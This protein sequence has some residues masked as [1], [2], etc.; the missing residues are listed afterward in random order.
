MGG[1]KSADNVRGRG[2]KKGEV[3]NKL[4]GSRKQRVRKGAREAAAEHEQLVSPKEVGHQLLVTI[5]GGQEIARLAEE[6][7]GNTYKHAFAK[8]WT[9]AIETGDWKGVQWFVEY[10][11]G[12][13]KTVMTLVGENGGP[14]GVEVSR[15]AMS[16]DEKIERLRVL[17]KAREETQND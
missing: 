1:T 14:L 7:G 2:A 10:I 4:G 12:K 13:P 16:R 3:R 15:K 17:A 9:V 11:I 6:S 8:A 5:N